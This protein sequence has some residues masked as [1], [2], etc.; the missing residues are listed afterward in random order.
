MQLSE[1]ELLRRKSREELMAMGVDPYP[2][3]TFDVNVTAA[4]IKRNFDS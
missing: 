2:A 3:A 1:Q 4:H